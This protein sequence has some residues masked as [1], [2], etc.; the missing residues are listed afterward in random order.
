MGQVPSHRH[1]KVGMQ[2]FYRVGASAVSRW[3]AQGYHIFLDLKLLDIPHTVAGAVRAVADLGVDLLTVH[4]LGGLQMLTEARKAAGPVEVIG[5]TVLTHLGEDA[6]PQLGLQGPMT[7]AVARLADLAQAAGLAGV[8]A[9][10]QEASLL[11][12]RWPEGRR[13]VPGIRLPGDGAG[14]QRRVLTPQAAWSAGATDLV[15]GR[16][17]TGSHDMARA[18]AEVLGEGKRQEEERQDDSRA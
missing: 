8:V 5:V 10:G 12:D 6:L 3:V 14:D 15:V 1:F 17:V 9:S 7:Q 4:T 13:V 18:L 16:T 11:K 2:L